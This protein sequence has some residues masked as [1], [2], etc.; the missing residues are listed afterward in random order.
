MRR[1]EFIGLLAIVLWSLR[2]QAQ[3]RERSRRLGVL[4]SNAESDPLGQERIA[5]LRAALRELGWSEADNLRIDVRWAGSDASRI[6][7]YATELVGLAP[8]VVV[9]NGTPGTKAME[10]ATHSIPIVFAVVNDPVDQGIIA[11]L[12][13]PGG[14][15]TGLSFVDFPLF[16]KSLDL[17]PQIA[18]K[19]ARVGLMFR[20]TDHPYYDEYLKALALDK[21]VLPTV[22]TRAAVTSAEEVESEVATLAAPP[23][24]GLIVAPDIFTAAHRRA[25]LGSVAQH[26]VPAI[27]AYRQAV[28]EGG[29]MSYAPDTLDIFRRSATYVDRILM[30]AKP[31]DLPAQTP[32][33]FEFV[34]NLKTAKSLGLDAPPT[35]LALADEVIE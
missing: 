14:N 31:G 30:G 2:A 20:P 29:L 25:I 32:V 17:L 1:R 23:A 21:Q 7:E 34:V 16:G 19:V 12:A 24:G 3:R 26:G 6:T 35:L 15:I 22:L 8:D 13:H 27:H 5:A 9:A 10:Q 33:K 4:M 28:V 18:P 11:S